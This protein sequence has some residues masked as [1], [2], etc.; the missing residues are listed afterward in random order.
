MKTSLLARLADRLILVPTTHRLETEG[1]VRRALRF[2]Q[3]Q[4]DVW[5]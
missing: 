2:G 1:K 3:G 4:L 5:M